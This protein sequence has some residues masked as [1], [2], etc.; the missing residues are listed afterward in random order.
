MFPY[1]RKQTREDFAL[2]SSTTVNISVAS[3]NNLGITMC[4]SVNEPPAVGEVIQK[5]VCAHHINVF[6]ETLIYSAKTYP[7]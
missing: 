3:A 1:G 5:R 2:A 7:S 4:V 6:K